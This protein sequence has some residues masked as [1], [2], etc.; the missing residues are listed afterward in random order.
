LNDSKGADY[1][2]NTTI[3][4]T[5]ISF[6]TN[7]KN[8]NKE[9]SKMCKNLLKKF[10]MRRTSKL[11]SITL[12]IFI[13]TGTLGVYGNSNGESNTAASAAAAKVTSTAT[14]EDAD[15]DAGEYVYA[16]SL[17]LEEDDSV[18]AGTRNFQK[19]KTAISQGK[20]II[21][22]GMYPL[23]NISKTTAIELNR[24]LIIKG[25]ER[26][27]GFYNPTAALTDN[28]WFCMR[29]NSGMKLKNL[30]I[31]SNSNS[32]K[33]YVCFNANEQ[34]F[35]N[36]IN[37][38]ECSIS[39]NVHFINFTFTTFYE[40]SDNWGFGG[41][42]ISNCVFENVS[43]CVYVTDMPCGFI[44]LYDNQVKNF[45]RMFASATR[46]NDDED[47]EG[48]V[49]VNPYAGVYDEEGYIK[50][51]I[52]ERNNV[53]CEDDYWAEDTTGRIKYYTFL[54]CK[55]ENAIIKD[56]HVEGMKTVGNVA[57]YDYYISC[58]N[59]EVENNT[60]KNNCIFNTENVNKVL[61]KSKQMGGNKI[62]K[63]NTYILESSWLES[64]NDKLSNPLSESELKTISTFNMY[65]IVEETDSLE[66]INNEI[67]IPNLTFPSY[68][69]KLKNI[70]ISGNTID[71][72][73]INGAM[74]TPGRITEYVEIIDNSINAA[75]NTGCEF[76]IVKVTQRI[77]DPIETI[78]IS[79]NTININKGK[80]YLYIDTSYYNSKSDLGKTVNNL[81]L[82]D[83]EVYQTGAETGLSDLVQN[84]YVGN[85]FTAR[86]NLVTKGNIRPYRCFL[87]PDADI[88][89]SVVVEGVNFNNF[90]FRNN[91]VINIPS[92]DRATFTTERT[93]L[94]EAQLRIN[95]NTYTTEV[96]FKLGTNQAG[97]NY[98]KFVP[99][100]ETEEVT[101]KIITLEETSGE[102]DNVVI[103]PKSGNNMFLFR[104]F[105]YNNSITSGIKF[106]ESALQ[107][108]ASNYTMTLT[109]KTID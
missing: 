52:A 89:Y 10:S 107:P 79:R 46:E 5:K 38:E 83:N 8:L 23:L 21:V 60:W 18:L 37:A 67:N 48:D 96:E 17:G 66:I 34:C 12:A 15:M 95:N 36:A 100:G 50:G 84:Y 47:N 7:Y 53:V 88:D 93:Y 22:D 91:F 44:E 40:P 99:Q 2:K 78:D 103:K 77:T 14:D 65:E 33:T 80:F 3:S 29:E 43:G 81:I 75:N 85:T 104:N 87:S 39:G 72:G 90:D 42:K 57:L 71:C 16:S 9:E 73:T 20:N 68:A 105:V 54:F 102:G 19:L 26:E 55:A 63:D 97:E 98:I 61:M 106:N 64:M 27:D 25:D 59:V 4:F 6:N 30:T 82:L 51:I 1:L 24:T 28:Y 109:I 92:I 49:R 56:N 101:Y 62:Y 35:I 45:S 70:K 74:F 41:A 69:T 108:L 13:M 32:N 58:K 31:Y 11:I 86:N 76:S 94:L